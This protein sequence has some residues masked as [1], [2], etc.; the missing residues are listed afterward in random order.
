MV[1]IARNLGALGIPIIASGP[2]GSRAMYSKYC[3]QAFRIPANVSAKSY[4]YDLL[5]SGQNSDLEGSVL[6]AGG[7]PSLEFLEE[8]RQALNKKYIVEEFIPELRRAMLDKAETLDLAMKAGVPAPRFWRI[9]CEQDIIN[10][11]NEVCFP[12]MV[13]PLDSNAFINEFGRKLFIIEN[14]FDEVIET[15]LLCRNRGQKI[16]LVE[17][18]P[19]PDSLLSSYYTY[20]TSSGQLLYD[21]T[22]SV[23]RRWPVNRGGGCFH[24]SEWLPETAALGRK[25][26]ETIGWQGIA[27][28]EFKRDLRDGQLKIIEVN[29]RFTAG[30]SLVT[31]CGAPI[32]LIIYCYLTGQAIPTFETY[33]QS[34]RMWYPMRDFLAY[35]QLSKVGELSFAAW[36]KSIFAQK[37][38][39]PYLRLNDL[40]P[41]VVEF[42]SNVWRFLKS[43]IGFFNKTLTRRS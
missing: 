26:F 17:M 32:D 29:G 27:N 38:V 21:Y 24:Q 19:G 3:Q 35:R 11:R 10:L 22:K 9:D 8:N 42:S 15:A 14:D 37:L 5:L 23:I 16:M 13:K 25:L 18:I 39:L 40:G 6:F 36:I 7:D 41:S 33:S 43:P 20:R 4:W 12:L 30:H 31:K 28:V 34:L 1:S 2:A